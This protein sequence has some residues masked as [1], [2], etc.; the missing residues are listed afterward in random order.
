MLFSFS[1]TIVDDVTI[2]VISEF[3]AGKIIDTVMVVI[4]RIISTP[5][6]LFQNRESSW[7]TWIKGWSVRFP[8]KRGAILVFMWYTIIN[9]NIGALIAPTVFLNGYY[10]SM[11][12]GFW[13]LFDFS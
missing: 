4:V 13:G 10:F 7:R 2:Y 1:W 5:T 8:K 9:P 6:I 12:K 3:K 11:D